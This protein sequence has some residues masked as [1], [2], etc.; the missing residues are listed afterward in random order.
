MM[1]AMARAITK[2]KIPLELDL[3]RTLFENGELDEAKSTV[4][5]VL[6]AGP[7]GD[8]EV[9]AYYLRGEILLD[10]GDPRRALL[11]YDAAATAAPD[12]AHVLSG[13]GEAL[14]RLWQFERAAKAFEQALRGD[15]KNAR[16]HRGVALAYDRM[17]R[18]KLADMHFERAAKLD[19]EAYPL[20]VRM[21]REDFDAAAREAIRE[22]PAPI[23]SRLG[24]IGFLVQD[25]PTLPMIADQPDEADPETL[26]VFFG[27]E[28]P[29]RFEGGAAGFTPNQICLFQRNLEQFTSTREELTD[30]IRT[31]MWH[32]IGHY[33]GYDED[34]LEELGLG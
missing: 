4:D 22:M 12:D 26:G 1:S 24:P 16:A 28:L 7:E 3:A 18:K 11:A 23:K 30:E 14:F 13:K 10:M 19:P 32:E 8:D 2:E 31:T 15:A 33:L 20:P 29:A 5:G 25:Y 21:S 27:E 9:E 6:L 34:A 17:D